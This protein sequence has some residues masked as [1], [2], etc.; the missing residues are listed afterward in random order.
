ML[1]KKMSENPSSSFEFHKHASSELEIKQHCCQQ[2]PFNLFL[3]ISP[4]L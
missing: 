4:K 2:L 1:K 3:V